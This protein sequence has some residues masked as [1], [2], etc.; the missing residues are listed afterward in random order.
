MADW[1]LIRSTLEGWV[2]G[3]T[4]LEAVWRG[5]AVP[6][7]FADAYIILHIEGRRTVGNDDI[8]VEYDPAQP[9]GQEMR[10]YQAGARQFTLSCQVR[11][12]RASDDFDALNY[13]SLIRDAVCLPQRTRDVWDRADVAFCQVLSEADVSYILDARDMSIAQIDLLVNATSL[14]E[15]TKIGYV[16][17]LDDLKFQNELTTPPTT[18]W[19][20][21]IE[22]T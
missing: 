15:D 12:S 17:L 10:T 19:T 14:V 8:V 22:V 3:V 21:D 20:G 6:P 18:I 9:I 13:T 5:Q 4:G 2:E 11:S 7:V 1:S 16:E